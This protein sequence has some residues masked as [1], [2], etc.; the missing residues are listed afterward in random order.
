M[1]LQLPAAHGLRL[2][3]ADITGDVAIDLRIPGDLSTAAHRAGEVTSIYLGLLVHHP[4]VFWRSTH[5]NN[6]CGQ[7]SP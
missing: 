2:A 5:N 1:E 4:G 7:F 6:E 3:G